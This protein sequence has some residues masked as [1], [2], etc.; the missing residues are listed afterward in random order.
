M[1]YSGSSTN[2]LR[3]RSGN[4]DG[5]PVTL[6]QQA[7]WLR[8]T[9]TSG[10]LTTNNYMVLLL[11]FKVH[12]LRQF[13]P[14]L[15]CSHSLSPLVRRNGRV[16]QFRLRRLAFV[17]RALRQRPIRRRRLPGRN[18]GVSNSKDI[19]RGGS[20]TVHHSRHTASLWLRPGA[21]WSLAGLY[22]RSECSGYHERHNP[23]HVA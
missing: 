23:N 14:F 16:N 12:M 4:P 22:A 6:L 2:Y 19:R 9:W 20:P 13:L 5:G 15:P 3:N 18:P 1:E 21:P 11:R 8:P 7:T 10:I 17:L